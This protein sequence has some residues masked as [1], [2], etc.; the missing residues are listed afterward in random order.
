MAPWASLNTVFS[1]LQIYM[2]VDK[3]FFKDFM[4]FTLKGMNY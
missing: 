1:F 3:G 2:K 4:N